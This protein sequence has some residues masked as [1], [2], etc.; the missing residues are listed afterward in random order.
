[1]RFNEI[2][3]IKNILLNE[4]VAAIPTETVYGLAANIYSE[5]AIKKIFELKKRPLFNPLI[6]HIKSLHYLDQVADEIPN[7]A[8]KL[9]KAFWPGP[10]T[11]V[12]RKKSTISDLITGGK[13]TVGIRVPNHKLTLTLLE[14]VDFPLAAPSA[15]TFQSISPTLP[16]HVE[17]NFGENL[18]ILDGGPCQLGLE[19]TILGF[20]NEKIILYRLGAIS[21]EEIEKVVGKI[22]IQNNEK[23]KPNAP[24][25]LSKHYSPKTKIIL[26]TDLQT[27]ILKF[28]NK[29]IGILQFG[30]EVNKNQF[31]KIET[32]SENEDLKEAASNFYNALHTLDLHDLDLIIAQKMPN[33]G[34]GKTIN[35]RL[36]RAISK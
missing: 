34:L 16:E 14:S 6:V 35:D 24:G 3:P 23:S 33:E 11:L 5:K 25:M 19:S 8:I 27:E 9:A 18:A 29:K 30:N 10:L 31:F 2:E 4:E 7:V 26:T 21:V 36:T 17:K 28:Q 13:K 12:L 20:E 15:N 32:L 22:H 1:M